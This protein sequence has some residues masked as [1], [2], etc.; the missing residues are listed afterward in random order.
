MDFDKV[1]RFKRIELS[2]Q[3]SDNELQATTQEFVIELLHLARVYQDLLVSMER[4]QAAQFFLKTRRI[5]SDDI[6]QKKALE[7]HPLQRQAID[8][9]IAACTDIQTKLIQLAPKVNRLWQKF[10]GRNSLRDFTINEDFKAGK[11]L[12]QRN[13]KEIKN[14]YKLDRFGV[15]DFNVLAKVFDQPVPSSLSE[16]LVDQEWLGTL[17]ELNHV[18]VSD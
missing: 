4:A 5:S 9:N 17:S 14:Q 18:S 6:N 11:H 15:T 2:L 1:S 13:L 12:W 16:I 8:H 3:K 7:F 10:E